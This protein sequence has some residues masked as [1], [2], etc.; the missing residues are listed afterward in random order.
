MKFSLLIAIA[1]FISPPVFCQIRNSATDSGAIKKK[2]V[3]VTLD[4]LGNYFI[5]TKKVDS[6]RFDSSLIVAINKLQPQ[7]RLDSSI[8]VI[9]ADSSVSLG[10]VYHVMQIAKRAKA[11]VAVNMKME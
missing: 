6:S 10:K 1:F 2:M 9:N 8:V 3:V 11:R 7:K 4:N 5:D